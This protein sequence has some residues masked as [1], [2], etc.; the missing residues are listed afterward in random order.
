MKCRGGALPTLP[1]KLY[2]LLLNGLLNELFRGLNRRNQ[3]VVA[4]GFL[5]F[6]Q[7]FLVSEVVFEALRSR[8]RY[9]IKLWL[10]V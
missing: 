1:P 6:L 3:V 10:L 5:I 4:M 8:W 2:E 9:S 7:E